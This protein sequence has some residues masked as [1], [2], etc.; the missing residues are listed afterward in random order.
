MLWGER[1]GV[2]H[3]S[4][5]L[6][7]AVC[8]LE[9]TIAHLHLKRPQEKYTGAISLLERAL[10][11]RVEKLGGNHPDTVS[12]QNTLETVKKK[13]VNSWAVL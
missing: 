10:S 3:V 5:L 4:L 2:F 9:F 12:T 7:C 1:T 8:V 11:I 6:T 13:F